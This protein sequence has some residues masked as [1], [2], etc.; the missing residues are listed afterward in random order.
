MFV[1]SGFGVFWFMV[2]T[3]RYLRLHPRW[4]L[5]GIVI[6]AILPGFE[7]AITP[8]HVPARPTPAASISPA[9]AEFQADCQAGPCRARA[10]PSLDSSVTVG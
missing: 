1:L 6:A 4:L 7:T 10:S 3:W 8:R 2:R 9:W 5:W